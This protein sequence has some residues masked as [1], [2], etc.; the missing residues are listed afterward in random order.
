MLRAVPA[1]TVKQ[2]WASLIMTGIKDIENRSWITDYRGPIFIH[3]GQK[4]DSDP[5][6]E[7][8]EVPYPKLW[9]ETALPKGVILGTVELVDI[10]TN[11]KSD[12]AIEGEHHWVL[13]NPDHLSAP[14]P[15]RGQ[16][17]LWRPVFTREA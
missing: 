8:V 4:W 14:I 9:T 12:W 16:M 17:G 6:P 10:V 7:G 5:L 1:L 13:R 3:A 11:S 15:W 2:P